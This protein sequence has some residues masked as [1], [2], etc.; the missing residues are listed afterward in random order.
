MKPLISGILL[1]ATIIGNV[2]AQTAAFTRSAPCPTDP[3]VVG[4]VDIA[5]M[6]QDMADELVRVTEGGGTPPAGGYILNLCDKPDD[7]FDVTGGNRI[8][9]VL[10]QVTFVCGGAGA[11][12]ANC[13]LDASRLQVLV[14]DT[15]FP[16]GINF[17]TF[18]GLTFARF[19]RG[20]SISLAASA[21]AVATFVNC[22]WEVSK[23]VDH[24]SPEILFNHF[25]ACRTFQTT[26]IMLSILKMQIAIQ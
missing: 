1:L 26:M 24:S 5:A 19:A 10:D 15:A 6:N 21:P 20:E 2:N 4:Y 7:V 11:T 16:G 18:E 13:V 23:R 22:V 9:P 14:E 8:R 17:V 12:N 25:S 3:S